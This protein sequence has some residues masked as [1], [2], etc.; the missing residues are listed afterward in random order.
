MNSCK[1]G[2]IVPMYKLKHMQE[3]NIQLQE[4]VNYN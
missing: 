1:P 4:L 3:S 2:I